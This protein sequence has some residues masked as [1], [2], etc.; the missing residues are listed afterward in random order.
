[1]SQDKITFKEKYQSDPTWQQKALT[2]YLYHTIMCHKYPTWVLQDTASHF[3]I[4][5]GLVS[6]NIRLANEMSGNNRRIA[7]CNTREDALKLIERR[8]YSKDRKEFTLIKL[9]ELDED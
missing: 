6:E 5:I 7:Q 3:E 2:I 9:D 4:S 1:M 8:R